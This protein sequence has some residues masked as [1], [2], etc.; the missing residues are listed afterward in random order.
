MSDSNKWGSTSIEKEPD[1]IKNV[2]E[3]FMIGSVSKE[4]QEE[5]L[6]QGE[7]QSEGE[8]MSAEEHEPVSTIWEPSKGPRPSDHREFSAP[9]WNETLGFTRSPWTVLTHPL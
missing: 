2:V 9:T 5:L 7:I 1:V 4:T 3:R 6:S 8:Q